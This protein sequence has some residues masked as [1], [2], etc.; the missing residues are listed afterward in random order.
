MLI[1]TA[2][3]RTRRRALRLAI[4]VGLLLMLCASPSLGGPMPAQ[5]QTG[6]KPRFEQYPATAKFR[7]QP[8]PVNLNS[9]PQARMFRTNLRNGAPKGP[10]FAGHYT[11]VFWGCGTACQSFAIVDARNGRVY[12]PDFAVYFGYGTDEAAQYQLDSRLFI[13]DAE[14][15]SGWPQEYQKRNYY[16][17]DNNRFVLIYSEKQKATA[18]AGALRAFQS[19][20]AIQAH[21]RF[22]AVETPKTRAPIIPATLSGESLTAQASE[23]INKHFNATVEAVAQFQPYYLTGDFNADGAEDL[24]AIVRLKVERGRLPKDVKVSNP[25]GFSDISRPDQSSSADGPGVALCIAVLHGGQGGWRGSQP[26]GKYLL[27]GSS[28]LQILSY[29]RISAGETKDLMSI[30][31]ASRTRRNK[32]SEYGVPQAARGAWI[33]VGTQVGE[34]LIYWDGKTYRFQDSAGD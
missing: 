18:N 25:F 29:E 1:S 3:T 5:S 4:L 16:R 7:G 34:G 9:H 28:P 12:F 20:P 27:L 8:A 26:A 14:P 17:W 31:P 24:L 32:Y 2:T 11:L 15:E 10:N 22:D 33:L 19:S 21:A 30:V 23:A 6:K 13:A